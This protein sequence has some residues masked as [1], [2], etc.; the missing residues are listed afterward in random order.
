[1]ETF[2]DSFVADKIFDSINSN[3]KQKLEQDLKFLRKKIYDAFKGKTNY[4]VEI[5]HTLPEELN[6]VEKKEFYRAIRAELHERN[7]VVKS[8]LIDNNICLII[9]SN[10]PHTNEMDKILKKTPTINISVQTTT[11]TNNDNNEAYLNPLSPLLQEDKQNGTTNRLSPTPIKSSKSTGNGN[12]N[13]NGTTSRL[14]TPIKTSLSAN[15][16]SS[17]PIKSS[18]TSHQPNSHSHKHKHKRT[19]SYSINSKSPTST[20]ETSETSETNVVPI[21]TNKTSE[22]NIV[23][24]IDEYQI[25]SIEEISELDM[26]FINRKL[27]EAKTNK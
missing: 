27:S 17:T 11:N 2:P 4:H 6:D 15:R 8:H 10:T 5:I 9:F 26:E 25:P 14:P 21:E 16:L 1:M 19:E 24:N 18:L 12:G 7:F 20:L 13:G 3:R 22:T 23:T